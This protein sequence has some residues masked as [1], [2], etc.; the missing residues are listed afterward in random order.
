M[1]DPAGVVVTGETEI[2]AVNDSGGEQFLQKVYQP[3][4][5]KQN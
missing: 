2:S 3:T 1:I 5:C 4:E